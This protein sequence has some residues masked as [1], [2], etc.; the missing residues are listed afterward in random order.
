MLSD[1]SGILRTAINLCLN[2]LDSKLSFKRILQF[3]PFAHSTWRNRYLTL[4]F[5]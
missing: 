2:S 1:L 4:L 3:D 5:S